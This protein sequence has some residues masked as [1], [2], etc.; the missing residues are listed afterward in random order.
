MSKLLA[1]LTENEENLLLQAACAV[2]GG[3]G[4]EFCDRGTVRNDLDNLLQ[5]IAAEQFAEFEQ[6]LTFLEQLLGEDLLKK[7][8][9]K[10][11]HYV[12]DGSNPPYLESN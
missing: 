5:K 2:L 11:I 1:N 9:G 3:T 10:N 4:H 8:W 7:I 12:V 6:K